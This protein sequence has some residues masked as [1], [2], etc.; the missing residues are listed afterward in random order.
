MFELYDLLIT[1]YEDLYVATPIQFTTDGTTYLYPLP[2]GSNTFLNALNLNQTFTPPPFYKLLGVDLQIQNTNNGYVN[3]QKFNFINRNEFIYP[4]SSSTIYGVFNCRYRLLGN[5]I[6]FIPT[7]SANQGVRIWY[8]PRLTQLLND[9]D[10]TNI[11]ISGWIEYVIVRAA[12]YVLGKEESDVTNLQQ[13][14]LFVKQRIE[15]TA[16]NRDAG[17][18]DTISDS[19][20]TKGYWGSGNG[21]GGGS[22]G[23][24]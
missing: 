15:E 6:E 13:Q 12:I 14:L 4:N 22:T 17:V 18:P 10:T 19:R 20:S 23:G 1:V 8:I 16:A 11:G 7:P 21:W 9:T 2:N 3:I 24:F 5:N